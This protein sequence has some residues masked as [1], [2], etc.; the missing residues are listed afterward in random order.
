MAED[1]VSFYV[2]GAQLKKLVR[3]KLNTADLKAYRTASVVN[4]VLFAAALVLCVAVLVL[5]DSDIRNDEVVANAD[6]AAHR[7]VARQVPAVPAGNQ[8]YKQ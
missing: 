6:G 4:G 3:E 8:A 2:A 1:I 7:T 5:T